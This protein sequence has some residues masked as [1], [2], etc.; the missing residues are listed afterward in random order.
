[1]SCREVQELQSQMASHAQVSQTPIFQAA[2]QRI[3]DLREQLAMKQREVQ[4]LDL[5][6]ADAQ[7]RLQFQDRQVSACCLLRESLASHEV[8]RIPFQLEG[9]HTQIRLVREVSKEFLTVM[10]F[11]G[12]LLAPQ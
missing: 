6:L 10:Q 3:A 5:K 2:Q 9:F 4:D 11:S 7:H 12:A 1:M 8:S